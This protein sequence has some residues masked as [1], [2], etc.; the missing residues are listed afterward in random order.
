MKPRLPLQIMPTGEQR[1]GP[2]SSSQSLQLHCFENDPRGGVWRLQNLGAAA[3]RLPVMA[4][5][6]LET[7]SDLIGSDRIGSGR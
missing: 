6:R 2:T 4:S 5:D 1:Y 3:R 7:G